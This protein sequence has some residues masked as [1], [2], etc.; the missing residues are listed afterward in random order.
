[1]DFLSTLFANETVQNNNPYV[2]RKVTYDKG[3]SHFFSFF[4]KSIADI[5]TFS[6]IT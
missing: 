6:A 2:K 1:M 5:F 4:Y 3:L